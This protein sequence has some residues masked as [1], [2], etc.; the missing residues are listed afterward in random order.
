MV[1]SCDELRKL[2]SCTG[3]DAFTIGLQYRLELTRSIRGF[4]VGS[5]KRLM[6][7]AL[8]IGADIG[9][10]VVLLNAET[11]EGGLELPGLTDE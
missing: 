3:L 8:D 11:R 5:T 4:F 7:L 10:Y 6:E 1:H 9:F 2:G